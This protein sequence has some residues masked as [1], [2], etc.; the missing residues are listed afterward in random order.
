MGWMTREIGRQP[1]TVY[2]LVR[3]SEAASSLPTASVGWT[4][5]GFATAYTFLFLVFC[6]FALRIL[7][8][9]PDMTLDKP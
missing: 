7:R 3:T 5:A 9:G 1:W 4:L 8:K 2:G 6:Y